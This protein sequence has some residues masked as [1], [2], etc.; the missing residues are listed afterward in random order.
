M[1]GAVQGVKPEASSV[2]ELIQDLW[3]YIENVRDSDADRQ[4]RFFALRE[5]VRALQ[6]GDSGGQRAIFALKFAG[7]VARMTT[8]EETEGGGTSEDAFATVD[9]LIVQ[10]RQI[11]GIDPGH[12][13]GGGGNA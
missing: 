11:T 9:S 8:E 10:A 5:R 2:P 3:W 7:M 4:Y 13:R 1:G 12:A 6:D